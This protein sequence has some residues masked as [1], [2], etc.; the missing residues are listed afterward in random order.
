MESLY[1]RIEKE[2]KIH[3]SEIWDEPEAVLS[4]SQ[5]AQLLDKII[6]HFA[7]EKTEVWAAASLSLGKM[8]TFYRD[9]EDCLQEY[10]LTLS[11]LHRLRHVFTALTAIIASSPETAMPTQNR[12]TP[13]K[14][15]R[16]WLANCGLLVRAFA[17]LP[18]SPLMTINAA[19][20]P[21]PS[22]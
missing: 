22:D 6:D 7:D 4:D 15:L 12:P 11:N 8:A 20:V 21:R 13:M 10:L 14:P 3:F 16:S 18:K 17:A 19:Q 1:Q 2:K 5:L 9:A